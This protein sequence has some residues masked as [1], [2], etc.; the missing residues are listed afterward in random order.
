MH[1]DALGMKKALTVDKLFL[2]G[3]C[4]EDRE[5]VAKS[6]TKHYAHILAAEDE[7]PWQTKEENTICRQL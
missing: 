4:A 1:H 7:Q 5:E 2:N 6:L 3:E